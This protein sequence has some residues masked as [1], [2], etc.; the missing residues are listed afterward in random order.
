[1]INVLMICN[2][3]RLTA[4]LRNTLEHGGYLCEVSQTGYAAFQRLGS[5]H[6]DLILWNLQ[7]E[8][9]QNMVLLRSVMGAGIPV[10]LAGELVGV[11]ERVQALEMGA[12]DYVSLPIYPQ[13]LLARM[14][15]ALRRYRRPVDPTLSVGDVAVI[16]ASG[17]V[18]KSGRVVRL[19]PKEL[20]LLLFLLRNKNTVFSREQLLTLVWTNDE[21][22]ADHA[23]QNGTRTVDIHIQRLRAKLGP[24]F[25]L[26]TVHRCGYCLEDP[27]P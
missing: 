24:G 23:I 21:Q 17:T 18:L 19:T 26:Y 20:A 10:I 7:G 15:V 11:D 14:Q 8:E 3:E 6:F 4:W 27:Q 2:D 12:E 9:R 1:M 25:S 13:E 22:E 16:E 5:E